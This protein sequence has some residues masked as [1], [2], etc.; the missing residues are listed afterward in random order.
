[1]ATLEELEKIIKINPYSREFYQLALEYQKFGKLAE[2]KSVLVK[3]LEKNLGNFQARLLLTK[4]FIAESNFKEAKKQIERVLMVVP[5]NTTANH[6]AA[7]ISEALGENE[8]A[9]RYY[10]VV[11]LF[12]PDR[13]GI[14]EKISELEN[15][16][17]KEEIIEAKREEQP[18]EER[19]EI[20]TE[21]QKE[22]VSLEVEEAKEEVLKDEIDENI[23]EED[24][25]GDKIEAEEQ[26]VKYESEEKTDE[27]NGEKT[28]ESFLGAE[29]KEIPSPL[30]SGLENQNVLEGEDKI[31]EEIG[32]DTLTDLLEES[33][34]QEKIEENFNEDS[35]LQESELKPLTD[36]KEEV[37]EEKAEDK[38]EVS[39]LST[40]TLADLYE[41][42]G[43]PE[44][45]IEIYQHILLKEPEREDIRKK[46]EKLKKEMLGMET[47]DDVGVVDVKSALRGK[48]IEALKEWLRRIRE[49]ENV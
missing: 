38:E 4:I 25:S 35:E 40:A 49:A 2:A 29:E 22:D 24:K 34:A 16:N 47:Q 23:Q 6:L 43:Y 30:Q 27:I 28:E 3:G 18:S 44:K 9:L 37:L 19:F 21:E 12:E 14:K 8:S 42:Q 39:S 31:S 26:S 5:D 36:I 32:E 7:E 11:Q 10:K 1:M 48:R 41:K 20:P 33:S 45:A 17:K 15:K 46:I 13:Q